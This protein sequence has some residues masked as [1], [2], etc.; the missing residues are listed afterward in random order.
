MTFHHRRELI[1]DI[2]FSQGRET[3]DRGLGTGDRAPDGNKTPACCRRRQVPGRGLARFL[4]GHLQR[5]DQQESRHL[6]GSRRRRHPPGLGLQRSASDPAGG[7][8]RRTPASAL[9]CLQENLCRSTRETESGFSSRLPEGASRASTP[10]RSVLLL[11]KTATAAA[12]LTSP[13]RPLQSDKLEW[14]SWTCVLGPG[15]E[16]IWPAFGSVNAASLSKDGKLLA[17]GDDFGFLKLFSFPCRVRRGAPLPPRH[18]VS[19]R[20]SDPPPSSRVASPS[21]KSTWPTAST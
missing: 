5:A 3:G 18:L 14:A 9:R 6:Q 8:S 4:C 1:S 10:P 19:A 17:S 13:N 11:P 12:A 2:R 20:P 7:P 21:S 15:C 16:G